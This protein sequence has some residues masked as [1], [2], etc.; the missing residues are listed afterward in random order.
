MSAL[1]VFFKIYLGCLFKAIR[2]LSQNDVKMMEDI[3]DIMNK[4]I[5][6]GEKMDEMIV[7]IKII[8]KENNEWED[9]S[10]I[11]GMITILVHD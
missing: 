1:I 6:T 10:G 11:K 5:T 4:V 8:Q 9:F 3:C 2:R 7:Q